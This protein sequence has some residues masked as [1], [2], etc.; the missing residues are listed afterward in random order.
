MNSIWS[1]VIFKAGF[2]VDFVYGRGVKLIFTGGRISLTVAF[3]G[4]NVMLGL[5]KC[6]YSLPVKRELGAATR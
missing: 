4:P 5:C 2:L 1:N 6:N 3:K